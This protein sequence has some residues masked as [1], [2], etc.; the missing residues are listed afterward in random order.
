MDE[1]V[2]TSDPEELEELRSARQTTLRPP[3]I[4]PS[5]TEDRQSPRKRPKLHHEYSDSPLQTPVCSRSSSPSETTSPRFQS[6]SDYTSP[7]SLTTASSPKPGSPVATPPISVIDSSVSPAINHATSNPQDVLRVGGIASPKFDIQPKNGTP[8]ASPRVD[9]NDP[10]SPMVAEPAP[11]STPYRPHRLRSESADP[12][13]LFTPSRP[14]IHDEHSG[15]STAPIVG[16]DDSP[17]QKAFSTA[18]SPLSA[19]SPSPPPTRAHE[20]SHNSPSPRRSASP[21]RN[22]E[23]LDLADQPRRYPLRERQAKQINP[24]QHDK[25]QYKNTLR[26]H[27]EAL[28]KVRSPKRHHARE[29]EYEDL[30]T[31][32]KPQEVDGYEAEDDHWE[33]RGRRS[34]SRS[35]SRTTTPPWIRDNLP[36]MSTDEEDGKGVADLRKEAHGIIREQKR[37]EATGKRGRR[38]IRPFPFQKTDENRRALHKS[39]SRRARSDSPESPIHATGPRVPQ[40]SSS[41]SPRDAASGSPSSPAAISQAP[42]SRPLTPAF[43]HARSV[44]PLRLSL[45]NSDVDMEMH[46]NDSPPSPVHHSQ[47]NDSPI[48]ISDDDSDTAH[49]T[50]EQPEEPESEPEILSKEERKQRRKIRALNRMYPAFMR[51]RMMK[52]GARAKASTKRQRSPT[53]SPESEGEQP[54]LPG[55]T[56][57]RRAEHPRDLRDIKGDTDSDDQVAGTKDDSMDE[58]EGPA[59]SD[60][61][62]EVVWPH[63][64]RRARDISFESSSEEA[65]SD[66]RIDDERIEAYLREAPVRGSGLQEKDMIDWMLANT[67][68]VGGTRRPSTR[69]KSTRGSHSKGSTRSKPSNTTRGAQR[70]G[71][72]RQTLLP[73]GQPPNRG[74]SRDRARA[75]SPPSNTGRGAAAS[76][77]REGRER[78]AVHPTQTRSPRRRRREPSSYL[79]PERGYVDDSPLLDAPPSPPHFAGPLNAAVPDNPHPDILRKAL[80]KQKEKERRASVKMHGVYT[81][82]APKGR[83]IITGQR[84]KAV[85]IDV[86]DRGFHEALAP[87]KLKKPPNFPNL[88]IA[89]AKPKLAGSSEARVK[90]RLSRDRPHT[91]APADV[92]IDEES[93]DDHPNPADVEE[94]SLLLD[95]GIPLEPGIEFS[96]DTYTG[97]G[98]LSELVTLPAVI[99][100]EQTPKPVLFSAHGF[101]LGPNLT[102][103]QFLAIIGDICDRAFEFATGI[104]EDDNEE[105]AKQW[106]GLMHATC[107]LLTWLLAEG[108]ETQMLIKDAMQSHIIRLTSQ[109]REASLTTKSMDSTTFVICWFVVE[110]S[111][112]SG[113]RS[114]AC[115]ASRSPEPNVLQEACALVIQYLLEYGVERGMEPLIGGPH[116]IDGSTTA[117]RAFEA[118]VGILYI[119]DKYRDST[120]TSA[121]PLWNMVQTALSARQ[122]AETSDF[123]ASENVWRIIFSLST[124][125]Q[126]SARCKSLKTIGIPRLPVCWDMVLFA[127]EGIRF[128]ADA[129]V[130]ETVSDSSLDTRDRYIKLV[131][132]RCCL[133]WSRWQWQLHDAFD[134]L[135]RLI[136][137]FRSRKFANLRQEKAEFPDFLRVN[138]WS[139]LSRAIHSETA[140]VL[141]LK[142]VYQ[143]LLVNKSKIKKLLSLATPVGSL[144]WS[145]AQPPSLHDLSMLFNRFSVI[146]IAIHV[147]PSQCAH[148]IQ[149]ARG[150]VKFKDVD[151]TTR[152]AYIRGFMYLSSVMVHRGIQLDEPLSWLDEMVTVL[153]DEHKQE[154]GPIVV[155]GIHALVVSVR[156]VLRAF[157]NGPPQYPDPR[158]LLSLERILRDSSLVKP[159]NAS[160]HIVPRLIRSFLAV[161]VLVVPPKRPSLPAIIPD[162][163]SQDEYGALAIDQDVLAALDKDSSRLEDEYKTKDRSLCRLLESV[164]WTLFRQLMQC[165][166]FDALKQ[167]FKENDRLST[168]I[169]SLTGCWLGCGNIMIQNSEKSW[170]TFLHPYLHPYGPPDVAWPTLDAFCH[171]RTNFLVFSN[172]LKLDP[173]AYLTLQDTFVIVLFEALASWHTTSEDDYVKL[174]LSIDGSQ[175]PLLK[176]ASWDDPNGQKKKG[177]ISYI[178]LLTAR[179][180]LITVILDNLNH[181]L[182]EAGAEDN[183]RYLGYC[184]KMF[185]AMKNVYFELEAAAKR[186]YASWCLQVYQ[187]YLNRPKIADE[188]RLSQWMTW[189]NGLKPNRQS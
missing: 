168:D 143:T 12:L 138:D 100:R 104:P 173:M 64:K 3:Q 89:H 181:C 92:E 34:Q 39:P 133:L 58:D 123:E 5:Q 150:Y 9:Y 137:I 140:F 149:K 128:Q 160:A 95:F 17:S 84:S 97:R 41:H 113:F 151:A 40:K 171:R 108:E 44:S 175:H 130:D 98:W 147:D 36:S 110:L 50:P 158:L 54:L 129:K 48:N 148:W 62:V 169:A 47:Q 112:R 179:L 15:S 46:G 93:D 141:F 118:W 180:P 172:V 53:V 61:D 155:L 103:P 96:L 101:D 70:R 134:T 145:A 94:R 189:A 86:A 65:L 32:E 106:I 18:L 142:L 8:P 45:D 83:R 136:D 29:E 35:R 161:R 7:A 76:A 122:S 167:S 135:Y 177:E 87:L 124:L 163:E 63:R 23:D 52:D 55:Q 82:I 51:D 74:L 60:S 174:L 67:A 109:M 22:L 27:P 102:V 152:H 80:R 20:S 111:I 21:P 16:N 1:I 116:R 6:S 131:V 139:L 125:P 68:A 56:R 11:P 157:K 26:H 24:Y 117:H 119:T 185:S 114:L 115:A 73:F 59:A 42:I 69:V 77:P 187:E 146:A 79:S 120:A 19:L 144:P 30:Q 75:H 72:E 107:Q 176:G 105:Q 38:A 166:K 126:V 31:Q 184:I 121:H 165:V 14:S 49:K 159:S 183:E 186:S 57:V 91:P 33:E 127:L 154:T 164:S 2:E 182:T 71:R 85:A 28:I 156:N 13:L 178:D 81:H 37:R 66:G 153:L 188:G 162:Q 43:Q 88:N 78:G 132:E 25:A 4:R 99:D 90:Q 170:P 10:G